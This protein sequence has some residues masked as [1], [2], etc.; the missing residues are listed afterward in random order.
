MENLKKIFAG[1]VLTDYNIRT[2]HWKVSGE[3][4]DNFHKL[5][6][7]YHE[8]FNKYID[9]IAE[10]LLICGSCPMNL[11]NVIKILNDDKNIDFCLLDNENTYYD[12]KTL[13]ILINK[14]LNSM[15]ACY[16]KALLDNSIPEEC[17]SKL[18]EHMY[19]LKLECKYKGT[20]RIK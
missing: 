11:L 19:W 6:D 3:N 8:T 7:E 17:K 16:N 2:L 12:A 5:A 18:H 1:L 4:F 20:N 9:E 15:I 14:M 10:I 13:I